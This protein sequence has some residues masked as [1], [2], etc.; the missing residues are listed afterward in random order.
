MSRAIFCIQNNH[1]ISVYL[2]SKIVN[3]LKERLTTI[4]AY[5]CEQNIQFKK[6]KNKGRH[7]KMRS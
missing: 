6:L 7:E 2:L 1:P 5:K 3:E 4:A